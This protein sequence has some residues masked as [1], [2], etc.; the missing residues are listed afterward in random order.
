VRICSLLPDHPTIGPRAY[1]GG[2][3]AGKALERRW[4]AQGTDPDV[5]IDEQVLSAFGSV[6]R[7]DLKDDAADH[8]LDRLDEIENA[9]KGSHKD[10]DSITTAVLILTLIS[11]VNAFLADQERILKAG[12]EDFALL[13]HALAPMWPYVV[14]L[15]VALLARSR[16]QR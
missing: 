12:F 10:G 7:S 16:M 1:P 14:V 8:L 5:T 4:C 13:G 11:A 3:F 15:L 2:R 9:V 6:A